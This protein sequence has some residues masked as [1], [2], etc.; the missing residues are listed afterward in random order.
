MIADETMAMVRKF[1]EAEE[2]VSHE[3]G[4]FYLF[5][6]FERR[7][8]PGRWDLVASAPWLKTDREG[9]LE[10]V[11][12]LRDKMDTGDWKIVASVLPVEPSGDFVQWMVDNYDLNHQT[13][14]VF[15]SG[16]SNVSVGHAFL[17]TVDKSPAPA[18][19]SLVA[20]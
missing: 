6:L 20:A 12:L 13:E 15:G 19:M 8:T 4:G 5:G 18:G 7:Q 14:E 11:M 17:I 1:R 10:L 9:T 16:F 3:R 2:K